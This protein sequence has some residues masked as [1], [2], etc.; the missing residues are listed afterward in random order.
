MSSPQTRIEY[1]G[2]IQVHHPVKQP[3]W[4]PHA[5]P[6]CQTFRFRHADCDC[7]A[8]PGGYH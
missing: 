3:W 4:A 6:D 7:G 8:I 5:G 2:N 1:T